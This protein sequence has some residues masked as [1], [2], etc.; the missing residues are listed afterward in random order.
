M[1]NRWII[2]CLGLTAMLLDVARLH[3][4]PDD[5]FHGGSGDGVDGH[6]FLGY[7]PP[8]PGESGRFVGGGGFDGYASSL[9]ES[10]TPPSG[11]ASGRFVGSGFDGHAALLA[12]SLPYPLVGDADADGVPDWWEGKNYLSLTVAGTHTDVDGDRRGSLAE[13]L[14]DT[15]PNDPQSFLRITKVDPGPTVTL[16]FQ[17]TSAHRLYELLIA[18]RP[19]ADSWPSATTPP[20]PGTGGEMQLDTPAPPGTKAFFKIRPSVPGS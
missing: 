7:S 9:F 17:P 3:A 1:S 2:S 6:V 14:A 8:S 11:G 10:Y 18:P 13:Y 16:T 12:T 15:D 5:R 4:A 19:D 20:Q